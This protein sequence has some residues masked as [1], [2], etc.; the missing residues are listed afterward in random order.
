VYL[1][2]VS[3]KGVTHNVL[4][5][6]REPETV[7]AHDADTGATLTANTNVACALVFRRSS[8]L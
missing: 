7:Q 1:S 8:A 4:I 6:V 5:V 3:I 2:A